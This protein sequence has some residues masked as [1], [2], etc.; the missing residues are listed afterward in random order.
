MVDRLQ[1]TRIALDPQA[2]PALR[3]LVNHARADLPDTASLSR[4]ATRLDTA[5]AA[6]IPGPEIA[7]TSGASGSLAVKLLGAVLIAGAA[8]GGA[9]YLVRGS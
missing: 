8:A 2:S 7:A 1:P 9:T 4:L 6:N 3:R 5:I